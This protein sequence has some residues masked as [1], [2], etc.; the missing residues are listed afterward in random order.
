MGT[1][2]VLSTSHLKT[3]EIAHQL[4]LV[5]GIIRSS[6]TAINSHYAFIHQK[7]AQ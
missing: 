6:S 5:A 2:V 1:R 3:G 7:E 4:F